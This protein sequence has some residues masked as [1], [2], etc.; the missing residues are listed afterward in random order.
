MNKLLI[1]AAL[2]FMLL[3]G[4]SHAAFKP[5]W[6]GFSLGQINAIRGNEFK[7]NL[8]GIET[9][10]AS[11]SSW[12]LIPSIGYKW[13]DRGFKYIYSDLRR[14]FYISPKWTFSINTGVGFYDHGEYI[15][16]G[17]TIEFRSGIEF[18]YSI[19]NNQKIGLS[20][21]HFSNSKLAKRKPGTE[22]VAL[23]YLQRF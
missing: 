18:D 10:F 4:E 14:P 7:N 11:I 5:Q 13:S 22:S 15:E 20:L 23:L 16:L 1:T 12:H 17:H 6:W 3:A 2:F 21:N 9:R 19:S 8:Y